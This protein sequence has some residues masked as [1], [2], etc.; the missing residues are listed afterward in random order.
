MEGGEKYIL[1]VTVFWVV[2]QCKLVGKYKF[3]GETQTLLL[4]EDAENLFSETLVSTFCVF[5]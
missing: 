4:P 2:A 5:Q 3:F 1:R